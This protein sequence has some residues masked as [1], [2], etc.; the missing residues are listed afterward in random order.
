[1]SAGTGGTVAA[2]AVSVSD[3]MTGDVIARL[4]TMAVHRGSVLTG[5]VTGSVPQSV[6]GVVLVGA[7]DV[8]VGFTPVD[9]RAGPLPAPRPGAAHTGTCT[10]ARRTTAALQRPAATW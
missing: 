4:R 10:V 3:D 8:A 2:T 1:M 5:H 6:T 9:P 7:A